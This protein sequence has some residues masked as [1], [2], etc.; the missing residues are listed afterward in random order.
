ML[1]TMRLMIAVNR[2]AL[3]PIRKRKIRMA[4]CVGL[5]VVSTWI[6][7]ALTEMNATDR[8]ADRQTNHRTTLT[9]STDLNR[10]WAT[11]VRPS[12]KPW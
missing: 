12:S 7:G 10:R 11:G 4:I 9:R 3:K 6:D 1:D 8:P 2:D 5:I